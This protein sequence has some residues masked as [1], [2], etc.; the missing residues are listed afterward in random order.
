MKPRSLLFLP[1]FAVLVLLIILA[2]HGRAAQPLPASTAGIAHPD[3]RALRVDDD[4]DDSFRLSSKTFENDQFIPSTMV[5][6][7]QIGS[8]CT[9]T[10]E[11]PQ[12]AWTHAGP[13]TRSYVVTLYDATAN[14]L[15]WG[16]FNIPPSVTHL[17][18]GAGTAGGAPGLQVVNDNFVFGYSGPCP[19]P[20][21]VPNGIH[22]YV[23]TVY[24]LDTELHIQPAAAFPPFGDS[25][26]RGMLGH[27]LESASIT[28]LFKCTDQNQGACN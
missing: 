21:I 6:N 15:H 27:V 24:A 2:G 14:F 4:P 19:P 22:R 28:G 25:L 12:L 7:G 26:Y 1:F 13:A 9:G 8:V 16:Q 20:D 10:N 5:F 17:D 18:A 11:S 23:F 3:W